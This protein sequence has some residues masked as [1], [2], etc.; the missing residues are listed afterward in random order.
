MSYMFLLAS[1][2]TEE[3]L[4]SPEGHQ[5]I[6]YEQLEVGSGK[7]MYIA[8]IDSYTYEYYLLYRLSWRVY[9]RRMDTTQNL[10]E[11]VA[12]TTSTS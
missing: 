7:T 12:Y 2:S 1:S 3:V 8:L 4:E 5:T 6:T 9:C 11:L 10:P